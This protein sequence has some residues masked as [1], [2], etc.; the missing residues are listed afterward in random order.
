MACRLSIDKDA[1]LQDVKKPREKSGGLLLKKG[2]VT[3]GQRYAVVPNT[4][5]KHAAQCR[6][7]Q[8]PTP[9]GRRATGDIKSHRRAASAVAARR[10]LGTNPNLNSRCS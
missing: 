8:A 6:I 9:R 4:I 10:L 5:L 2:S 7:G 1:V 3:F